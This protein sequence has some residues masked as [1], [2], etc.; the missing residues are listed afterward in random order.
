MRSTGIPAGLGAALAGVFLCASVDAKDLGVR[1]ATWAVAEPDLLTEIEERLKALEASGALAR[2]EAEA[3]ARARSRIEA[4][5]R[6]PGIRPATES[7]TRR[8]DPSVTVR[9]DIRADDG[10]LIAAAGTRIEPFAHTPLT[11]DLLFVDGTRPVEI[12]WAL[13]HGRPSKI[14]LVA[15]RPLELSRRHGRPF[16]FDQGG[17]LTDRLGIAATPSLVTREGAGLRIDEIALEDG[18]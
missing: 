15:G 12:G 3:V 16:F 11:R 4:P 9:E 6:V 17:R 1:G 8:F 18:R 5:D 7:R 2:F 10:T 14:V 13:A